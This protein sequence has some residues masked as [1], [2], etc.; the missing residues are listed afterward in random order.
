VRNKR[1]D[2]NM[3]V[4]LVIMDETSEALTALRFASRRAQH[5]GGQVHILAL[6]PKQDFVAWG[7]V[8]ATIEDEARSRAEALVTDAA[9][10]L[11]EDMGQRPV[12]TVRMG[13]ATREIRNYMQ[14]CPDLAMLVLGA[15]ATGAPGP[16]IT[17]FAGADAGALPCPLTIVP[18][19]LSDEDIDRM[20]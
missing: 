9:G 8:Q 10:A 11:F 7:G 6:V 16:L 17:H 15:A 14:E 18:G 12:I 13:D 20:S 5:T 1:G 4:Y 2:I 19:G 3:R